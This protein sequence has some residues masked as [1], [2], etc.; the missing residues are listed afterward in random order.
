[1]CKGHFLPLVKCKRVERRKVS[2]LEAVVFE[3]HIKEVVTVVFLLSSRAL[4]DT[5]NTII[6][7][8]QIQ[9]AAL[10]CQSPG[11]IPPR[12][13]S[14]CVCEKSACKHAALNTETNDFF[15]CCF[16]AVVWIQTDLYL[17]LVRTAVIHVPTSI[18][19]SHRPS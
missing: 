19:F 15:C 10:N 2:F 17:T 11:V 6:H 18:A 14:R 8:K 1:M 5:K 9:R 12:E 4:R 13:N 16:S 7:A 3:T